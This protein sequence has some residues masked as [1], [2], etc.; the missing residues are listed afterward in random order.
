VTIGEN[1][2]IG[3]GSVVTRDIPANVVAA[4]NPARIVKQ[5]NPKRRMLTRAWLF[6]EARQYHFTQDQIDRYALAGNS[7]LNWLRSRI[8]PDTAD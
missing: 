3:A 7:W 8:K 1:S 5:L 4:G 2:V 6:D